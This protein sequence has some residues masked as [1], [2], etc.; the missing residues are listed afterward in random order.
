MDD[1]IWM[2]NGYFNEKSDCLFG[3]TGRKIRQSTIHTGVT[4]LGVCLKN[5]V[6]DEMTRGFMKSI[7][8]KGILDIG[9]RYDMRD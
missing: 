6:V 3:M 1:S 7:G 8:Y 4:S 9:Y 2:F 5:Q